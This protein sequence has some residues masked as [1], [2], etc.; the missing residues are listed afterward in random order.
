MA[1]WFI[2]IK[3]KGNN[4]TT[5]GREFSPAE[6]YTALGVISVPVF[7]IVGAGSAIFWII[8][9]SVVITLLHAIMMTPPSLKSGDE[10]MGIVMED[11]TIS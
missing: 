3:N 9:A 1:Y 2:S 8:G 7:Y 4:I 5:L 6:L 10:E 11:V